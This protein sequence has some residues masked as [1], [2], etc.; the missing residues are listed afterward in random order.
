M[1]KFHPPVI[2]GVIP[3][4]YGS[5]IEVPY[6]M[7]K[8]V[9][10]NQISGFSLKIKT[11]QSNYYLGEVSCSGT[12][13][14]FDLGENITKKLNIGQYYKIQI[15]YISN[16]GVIG[17]YS[18]V[19]TVK[20]TT[21]PSIS[22]LDSTDGF[23]YTGLYSQEDGDTT[24]KIYSYQFDL[25][26]NKGQVIETSSECLHNSSFDT[27]NYQSTD[28]FTITYDLEPNITYYLTYK[29]KTINGLEKISLA[30]RLHKTDSIDSNLNTDLKV[31]LNYE[32]GYVDV[33]LQK[34]ADVE[35]EESA[36][37][38]FILLRADSETNFK[39]WNEVL[40]FVLYGQQ[41]SRHLWK[42]MTVKQG[43]SYKYAIQQYNSYNLRSNKIESDVVKVDFEYAYLFDGERQLKIKYNPKVSS[44][45]NTVLESKVDTIGSQYPFIFRN[46]NVKYKEFPISGLIS[47]LS[48]ENNLFYEIEY[49]KL[50]EYRPDNAHGVLT[51]A[52]MHTITDEVLQINYQTYYVKKTIVNWIKNDKSTSDDDKFIKKE[53]IYYLQL[54]D[55]LK[56]KLI[57][58]DLFNWTKVQTI[59]KEDNTLE[60][61][62][63]NL[64]VYVSIYEIVRQ[65]EYAT[66]DFEN[67][68][69]TNL[70]SPNIYN[71]RN[72][73]LEVLE[74]LTN[75]EPKLFRSPT[76]GNYLVRLLNVSLSPTDSLGRMLHTFS[77][78]AYEIDECSYEAL[79][80]ADIIKTDDVTTQ[81][82]RVASI[83]LSS[84][85]LAQGENL[86]SHTASSARLEGLA[87]G[88]KIRFV[89]DGQ[90]HEVMIGITG[91]YLIELQDDISI[92]SLSF[93]GGPQGES[94]HQGILTYAY[95]TSDFRDSFD[96]INTITITPV[97][98]RQFL[99]TDKEIISQLT[100]RKT[101]LQS[102][103]QIKFTLRDDGDLDLYY[104]ESEEEEGE[105]Y[106]TTDVK[107]NN[108]F[109]LIPH[110]SLSIYKVYKIINQ[111]TLEREL[112]HY[113]DGYSLDKLSLEDMEGHNCTSAW[114]N[115]EQI[116]LYDIYTYTVRTPPDVWALRIGKAVICD[117]T[118]QSKII[119]YDVE[120]TSSEVIAAKTAYDKACNK[121]NTLTSTSSTPLTATVA[122]E[123]ECKKLYDEYV[124]QVDAA[125][126]E[127]ERR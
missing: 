11:V 122:Q 63:D 123:E 68:R 72:F 40:K 79:T 35:V 45:K 107:G 82:L 5:T 125:I 104:W 42:D 59:L 4:F 120:N 109:D 108:I 87:P 64:K 50:L 66:W 67:Q 127:A 14:I 53:H 118:Y 106:Y 86:L 33:R 73:K 62:V 89:V 49:E 46:G 23:T 21:E 39:V 102:I 10:I 16:A 18:T 99:S 91:S 90:T 111:E 80:K 112:I 20:Y 57:G 17:Y 51:L 114:I 78:T 32:D 9:G 101:E 71:E 6:S 85:S 56:G 60:T 12:S 119:S 22:V 1:V 30:K 43:V 24:E 97:P 41:P 2:E 100:N 75:G 44:F 115:N 96:T 77:A 19:A 52:K 55:Y 54:F 92:T 69:T 26:D 48:D 121:L 88:E 8:T 27:E 25:K 7:N 31:E 34:P 37:G 13:A 76:E 29:V 103:G 61:T 15:A 74:W 113:L 94:V 126:I 84:K 116:D 83:D 81:Q 36:V 28:S 3:A 117:L 38:S 95:Y 124:A 105:P 58:E 70:I 65:Q 47:L 93:I 110:E 98:A